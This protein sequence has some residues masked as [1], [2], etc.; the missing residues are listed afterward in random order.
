MLA[1]MMLDT[2]CASAQTTYSSVRIMQAAKEH[3]TGMY[4]G[5]VKAESLKNI[6]DQVFGQANVEARILDDEKR[7]ASFANVVIEFFVGEKIIRRV[8]V[9]FRITMERL[10]PVA[11]KRI[12]PGSL[13]SEQDIEW[14]E[15]TIAA[16]DDPITDPQALIGRRS[17]A[18]IGAGEPIR[19][20]Y[21]GAANGV[22]RNQIVSM[23]VRTGSITIRTQG[24]AIDDAAPGETLQVIRTGGQTTILC[25]VISNG[26][27]E[28]VR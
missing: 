17:V 6:G 21:L 8:S 12:L 3:I 5:A 24:K 11:S 22:V 1:L 26:V 20:K 4:G 14:K 9:P 13:I 15:R 19:T 16:N 25:R 23:I 10:V 18:M 7:T 27:V 2:H 28:V